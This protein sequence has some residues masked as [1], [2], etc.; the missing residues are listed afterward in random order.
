MKFATKLIGLFS[1][2]FLLSSF[3][4]TYF[5]YTSNLRI[6]EKEI[7]EK[8]EV[9]AFHTMNT[10]DMMLFERYVDIKMLATDPVISSRS[11]TP[12]QIEERMREFLREYKKYASLSFFNLNRVRIADTSGRYMGEKREFVEYWRDIAAGKE[13]VINLHRSITLDTIVI[14]FVHLVKDIKGVPFGVVVSRVPI[15]VLHE[16]TRFAS[17]LPGIRDS[18]DNFGVELV[19]R[20]GIIL[21]SND[22]GENILKDRSHYWNAIKASPARERGIGSVQDNPG[23]EIATFAREQGYLDFPGNEWTLIISIPAKTAFAPAIQMRDSIIGISS[24]FGIFSLLIIFVFSRTVSRPLLKFTDAAVEIA[25]GNLDKKVEVASRD[26]I[27]QMAQAFNNMISDIKESM[28]KQKRSEEA[29]KKSEFRN[30]ALLN[31]IPDAMFRVSKEGR[32]LDVKAPD[33]FLLPVPIHEWMG[34]KLQ[35]IFPPQEALSSMY[36]IDRVM[37]TGEMHGYDYKLRVGDDLRHYEGRIVR[38]GQDE[39]IM[40][41]RDITEHRRL[42][43]QLR[44]AQKME[45]IG[46]LTG[47][48]A[49]EFNNIM[50]VILGFGAFLQENL[51]H[52][53]PLRG[54]ADQIVA[55][56]ERATKLT[57]GLLA[58]SRRQVIY[59]E[60][61][62][63]VDMVKSIEVL[64][65]SLIG[66]KIQLIIEMND[67]DLTVMADRAQI[68]QVL[69]NLTS[70]AV[71]AMPQGG[72]LAIRMQRITFTAE[73]INHQGLIQPGMYV[74]ISITDTGTGMD[75]ETQAKIFEPFFTTKDVGKGTGL[76]LS[77]VYGIIKRHHGHITVESDVGKGT[78]FTVYLP[79]SPGEHREMKA[80]EPSPLKGGNETILVAEDDESVQDLIRLTLGKYGFKVVLARNGEEAVEKFNQYQDDVDLLL[81]DIAMP[82]KSG[83]EAYEEIRKISPHARVLFMSGHLTEYIHGE[84]VPNEEISFLSKPVTPTEL[85][86]KVREI[87]DNSTV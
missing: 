71:D 51:D 36:R 56:A 4:V 20:N 18:R 11:H 70:N 45:A 58:Y 13:F 82:G 73:D 1:G 77:V 76:G 9:Q 37:K 26:E 72:I 65:L 35:D 7:R 79:F 52:D 78:T 81:F 85:I 27:G 31:A 49:H 74:L 69:M 3:S 40:I 19:D 47:G 39:V 80:E 50:N 68:E 10:I 28:N 17:G 87:L 23:E 42:E 6:M 86:K 54:Y 84:G 46:T 25:Q 60:S 14:H 2:L 16:M 29:L 5:V 83:K 57:R 41:V 48:V 30:R 67:A 66:E 62:N 64:L 15:D 38:S 32:F 21:Y 63:L 44:H 53:N 55:S 43:E 8:M 61:V 24:A 75:R 22:S 59:T 33:G 34:A 12:Q